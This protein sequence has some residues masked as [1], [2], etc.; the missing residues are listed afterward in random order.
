MRA[1]L[2]LLTSGTLLLLALAAPASAGGGAEPTCVVVLVT[3]EGWLLA[4]GPVGS[5]PLASADRHAL[6]PGRTWVRR[7]GDRSD[8]EQ[9]RRAAGDLAR[10]GSFRVVLRAADTLPWS[11]VLASEGILASLA[12]SSTVSVDAR[13]VAA[14]R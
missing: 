3:A 11:E 14:S 10:G 4:E 12:A 7:A 6:A 13:P 1:S 5:R 9:L 8:A 2:L